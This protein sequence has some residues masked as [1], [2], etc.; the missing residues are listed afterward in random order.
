MRGSV[1]TPLATPDFSS[2]LLQAQG[3][4]ADVIGL[5]IGPGDV[6]NLVKQGHESGVGRIGFGWPRLSFG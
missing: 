4:K 6:G 3:S 5:A 1:Y 2:F